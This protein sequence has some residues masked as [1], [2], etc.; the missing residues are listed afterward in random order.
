M[1]VYIYIYIYICFFNKLSNI[2]EYVNRGGQSPVLYA[3]RR[4]NEVVVV[5]RS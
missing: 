3:D 5:R 2:D 1:Y 4:A